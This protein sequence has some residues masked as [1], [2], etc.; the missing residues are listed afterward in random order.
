[1]TLATDADVRDLVLALGHKIDKIASDVEDLKADV[2]D[3]K[4]DVV[5]LK[6]DV[7]DIKADMVEVKIAQA[8][9][10]ERFNALD[11]GLSTIR[12]DLRG[13]DARLWGFVIA[14]FLALVGILT[15]VVFFPQA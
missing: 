8:R 6:T 9:T 13:Q 2:E 11:A 7:A 5:E 10:D 12:T 4:A 14:L 3:L 15:K 1:M